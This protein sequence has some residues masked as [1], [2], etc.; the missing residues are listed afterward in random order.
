MDISENNL[1]N[2]PEI[3]QEI[4]TNHE[5]ISIPVIHETVTV[6]KTEIETGRIR[7]A[8]KVTEENQELNIPL[9]HEE[10]DIQTVPVNQYVEVIPEPVRYEGDTMIIPVLKEVSVIRVLL[11]KEIRITKKRVETSDAQNVSLRKEEIIIEN[12]LPVNNQD[13]Q[14]QDLKNTY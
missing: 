6:A 4:L 9:Q 2:T 5:S 14:H 11:E 3:N 12:I 8:K 7:I 13:Q 10:I 1:H